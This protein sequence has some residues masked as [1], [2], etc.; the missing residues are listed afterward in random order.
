MRDLSFEEWV[1]HLFDHPVEG[2]QWFADP[3][4]PY[5]VGPAELTFAWITRLFE[6]PLTWLSR[7]TDAQLAQGFWY[8]VSNGGSDCMV[9]LGDASVALRNRVR[10][11]RAFATVF[12]RVF[13][14][15]C[16]WHL[17]HLGEPGASA[18]DTTCYMWW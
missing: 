13:A 5:W 2:P 6:D 16:G 12:R 1:R 8:L 15:R 11:V 10:C 4:A 3:D 7:Y 9:A 17:S 14:V 18:L